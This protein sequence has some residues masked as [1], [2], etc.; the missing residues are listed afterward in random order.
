[1]LTPESHTVESGDAIP[2]LHWI[3][4]QALCP[5]EL[6]EIINFIPGNIKV[7]SIPKIWS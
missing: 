7:R 4:E 3:L 2:L 5:T 6:K 1:M